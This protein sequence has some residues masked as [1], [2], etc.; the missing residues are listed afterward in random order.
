M[1]FYASNGMYYR[2]ELEY[3]LARDPLYLEKLRIEREEHAQKRVIAENKAL[4]RDYERQL[5][6][7]RQEGYKEFENIQKKIDKEEGKKT[8]EMIKRHFGRELPIEKMKSQ[9]Y[10][11]D[12]IQEI[13]SNYEAAVAPESEISPE[14]KQEYK[15]KFYRMQTVGLQ[16]IGEIPVS[17]SAQV[18]PE[19][20]K[21]PYLKRYLELEP[22]LDTAKK[23]GVSKDGLKI[24]EDNTRWIP[25]NAE[26]EIAYKKNSKNPVKELR[27]E[28]RNLDA[29][30]MLRAISY[31]GE[32]KGIIEGYK[33]AKD[34]SN[35]MK[36]KERLQ[37][38]MSFKRLS[39]PKEP[40]Y[41][42]VPS[43]RPSKFIW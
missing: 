3:R 25:G 18:L 40:Y 36:P 34:P 29:S 33:K 2:S 15:D 26:F 42:D 17:T 22:V 11:Y 39:E 31:L 23:M 24:Y 27:K 8:Q 12:G 4:E 5:Y 20:T 7:I 19:K 14:K 41:Q 32:L 6:N 9:G 38:I 10:D 37:A 21:I 13:I 35:V 30:R 1:G 43:V 16:T 28:Y